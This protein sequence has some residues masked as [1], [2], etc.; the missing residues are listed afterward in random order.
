MGKTRNKSRKPVPIGRG[1]RLRYIG[2]DRDDLKRGQSFAA[3]GDPLAID[4]R[5]M[6][7]YRWDGAKMFYVAA[8]LV[9]RANR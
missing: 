4:G 7:A 6:V 1:A 9:E 2:E 8:E 3:A 5:D